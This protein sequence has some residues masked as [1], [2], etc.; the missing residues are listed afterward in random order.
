[1]FNTIILMMA[2]G[3]TDGELQMAEPYDDE[4]LYTIEQCTT[5]IGVMNAVHYNGKYYFCLDYQEAQWNKLHN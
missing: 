2:T 3:I 4:H 5:E 1:M